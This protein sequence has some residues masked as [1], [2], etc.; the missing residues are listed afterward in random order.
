MIKTETKTKAVSLFQSISAIGLIQIANNIQLVLIPYLSRVF[1]PE[2]LGQV[3]FAQLLATY[4]ILFI[5][6]GFSWSATK[7][8]SIHR[9]DLREISKIFWSVWAAQL[10]LLIVVMLIG[11][12]VSLI[13][14]LKISALVFYASAFLMVVGNL[15]FPSW[16]F[17]GLERLKDV[18]YLNFLIKLIF[19][20]PVFYFINYKTD[21]IYLF[22]I[23]GTASIFVG[24]FCLYIINKK[25]LV[26]FVRPTFVSI[27]NELGKTFS[28][29]MSKIAI[30]S[31]TDLIPLVLGSICGDAI[32]GLFTVANKIRTAIQ[33]LYTPI[34]QALFPRASFLF[35][36]DIASAKKMN[37]YSLIFVSSV[38]FTLGGFLFL[39]ADSIVILIAGKGFEG[40]VPILKWVSFLPFLIG[41]SNIFAFQILLPNHMNNSLNL[42]LGL[43][44]F[45]GICL[46]FPLTQK[47]LGVG[48]AQTMLIT[49]IFVTLS[50]AAII[51]VS[52]NKIYHLPN[53]KI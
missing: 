35:A 44:A 10:F 46:V 42:I 23:N 27:F 9:H 47:N 40:S 26:I 14:E 31:Y 53:N 52:K 4:C 36:N 8:I 39:F 48:A 49:E 41:V 45:I 21:A 7:R 15:L 37:I 18:A 6:Y 43:A 20:L 13:L 32:L 24:I 25:R 19:L 51:F 17:Q 34:L 50:M 1:G 3:T 22:L 38:T 28:L 33:F 30:T 2:I 16:L 12:A 29:F 11:F 5:D